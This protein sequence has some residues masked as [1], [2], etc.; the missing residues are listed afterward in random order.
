MR[1]ILTPCKDSCIVEPATHTCE[2][3]GR[4]TQQ[5]AEWT[6]YTHEQRKVIIKDNK[7]KR[8]KQDGLEPIN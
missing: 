4:T 3:C 8:K 5:V 2:T 6:I 7:N 1:T